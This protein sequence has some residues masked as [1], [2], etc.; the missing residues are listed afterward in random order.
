[1]ANG[2]VKALSL[3]LFKDR[4]RRRLLVLIYYGSDIDT[5]IKKKKKKKQKKNEKRNSFAI[6]G[7]RHDEQTFS[8]SIPKYSSSKYCFVSAAHRSELNIE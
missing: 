8:A 3:T 5:G 1:M 7:H 2:M 6:G 4:R